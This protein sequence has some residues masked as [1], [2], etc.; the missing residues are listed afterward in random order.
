MKKARK[1]NTDSINTAKLKQLHTL[2]ELVSRAQ[3]LS[4]VGKQYSNDRDIYE[5]L[6]YL[7]APTFS[8]YEERYLRQDIAKRVNDAPV[9]AT[10]RRHFEVRENIDPEQTP[11]EKD[12]EELVNRLHLFSKFT[13]L[14]K[15]VGFGEYAVLLCGFNDVQSVNDFVNPVVPK[16]NMQL[17]YVQPYSSDDAAIYKY[18][19]DPRDARYGLPRIYQINLTSPNVGSSKQVYVHYSRIIHVAENLLT[20]E[21][22]GQPRLQVVLNRLF[23][24]EKLVGGSAEMF[25]RGAR[26][27]YALIADADAEMDDSTTAKQA[28]QDELDEFEHNLRR[29]LRLQGGQVKELGT[30]VASPKEQVDVCL[31]MISAAT[32]IPKRILVGSERGELS[33]AQDTREWRQRIEERQ[34][35]YAEAQIVRPFI[36]DLLEY[37]VLSPLKTKEAKYS[38]IWPPIYE[39]G[40]KDKAE[41]GK[42]KTEALAKY[43][44]SIQASTIIPPSIY[45]REIL[46]LSQAQVDAIDTELG[47]MV[48]AET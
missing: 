30:Q 34:E 32:G 23:D 35:E 10:W 39:K 18:V 17:L 13:R 47:G 21:V 19:D 40:E 42:M 6:G 24:L 38:V 26:P 22:H 8:D 4:R 1:N 41:V 15:L 28:F 16:K 45:L 27:G 3:L 33:S 29:W 37:K 31:Q 43:A 9:S 46:G 20:D 2:S 36:D 7:R 14:D 5:A 25:W 12:W 44:D 11:F 48:S